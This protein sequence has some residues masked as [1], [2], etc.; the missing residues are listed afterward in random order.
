MRQ[1]DS[2]KLHSTARNPLIFRYRFGRL[3]VHC[4]EES[5]ILDAVHYIDVFGNDC[6]ARNGQIGKA[7]LIVSTFV[8]W[9]QYYGQE[10]LGR[11]D[12]IRYRT[13]PEE[14]TYRH[15]R[16]IQVNSD[17]QRVSMRLKAG[18]ARSAECQDL[19]QISQF[20]Q[21]FRVNLGNLKACRPLLG[22]TMLLRPQA[23]GLKLNLVNLEELATGDGQ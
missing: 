19:N 22:D 15:C 12:A 21:G 14:G 11:G 16:R 17:F 9:G 13:S 7:K 6:V 20:C 10:D 18:Q 4:I 2:S 3:I 23:L 5:V 1:H 8:A